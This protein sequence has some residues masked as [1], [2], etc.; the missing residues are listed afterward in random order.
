MSQ[1]TRLEI[2]RCVVVLKVF[3]K[4]RS[5][6]V[7]KTRPLLPSETILN[8]IKAARYAPLCEAISAVCY[9]SNRSKK[10]FR[11]WGIDGRR[12]ASATAADPLRLRPLIC[13]RFTALLPVLIPRPSCCCQRGISRF[14]PASPESAFIKNEQKAKTKTFSLRSKCK[15]AAVWPFGR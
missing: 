8:C 3:S 10:Q 6:S 13:R 2:L 4:K 9:D 12:S 1:K 14:Y 7:Q 5:F 11:Q 15:R